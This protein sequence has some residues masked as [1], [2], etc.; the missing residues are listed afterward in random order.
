M[1]PDKPS[2]VLILFTDDQR[3]DALGSMG[4]SPV[5]TPNMD[6]LAGMGVSFTHAH[7]P[8]GTSGAVCMPSRAMLHTGRH[9]FHLEDAGERIPCGHALMGEAFRKAGYHTYGIG[10]WH[11]GTDSYMRSFAD[12]AE[13]FFGGMADHWNV[14]V[15]HYDPS[16][17]YKS[18]WTHC[19][20]LFNSNWQI[21]HTCDHVNLG[22]HSSEVMSDASVRFIESYKGEKPFFLYTAFLAPHDPRVMPERFREMYRADE[23]VLPENF[24]EEHYFDTGVRD[25]RDEKLA[26]Y[27]R[28][29]A[30]IR[31]HI[32]EY[33]AM[34][35]HLDECIGRV[36][37]A[38]ERS[39]RLENTIIVLAGDNGLAVG[40]HGL[41]GKQNLY[42]HSVRVPLLIAGPGIPAGVKNHQ[43]V[44]LMDI[45]PTLC[46]LCGL[47]VPGT[48]DGL[49]LVGTIRDASTKVRDDLL[50]AYLGTHRG[51]TD[52][53]F[54][55]I[56]Y[57]LGGERTMSQLFDLNKD[58]YELINLVN[59]PG[60]EGRV[61]SMRRRLKDLADEW[62]DT[63]LQWG[64]AFWRVMESLPLQ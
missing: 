56:E 52:G 60:H 57:V 49:S 41:M 1:H 62:E 44:Y 22:Q 4:G 46:G 45:F 27:P 30:E 48:V 28:D 24:M 17:E 35:S 50:L 32:A 26:A 34:I 25:I 40:Q 51:I 12:G 18:R 53:S 20:N 7:I 5:R 54:K 37:D 23:I 64:R 15:N 11:N 36:L 38:L 55:L 42:D 6:R 10:K 3:F 29:A 21:T 8:G 31:R 43:L 14:P 61:R 33:Y 59:E 16:G 2:N 63:S 47:E 58:P 9:L 19:P 39:G 13:I